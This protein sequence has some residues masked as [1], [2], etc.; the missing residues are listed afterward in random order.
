MTNTPQ[1]LMLGQVQVGDPALGYHCGQFPGLLGA[2]REGVQ[3]HD[4]G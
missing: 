2:A 1:L 4:S 3:A